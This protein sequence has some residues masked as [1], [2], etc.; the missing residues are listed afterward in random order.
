MHRSLIPILAALIAAAP[1]AHAGEVACWF[2]NGVVVVPAQLAGVAGD[3]ILD[4]ATPLTQM[5]DT[6]AQGAGF[7][8]TALTG[9][10][11]IAG[12]V[13]P[14]QPAAVA[15]LDLRTGALPTPIAGVIGA[16]ALKA[17]VLDVQFA[18]CRVALW[19][20]G[21]TP[22]FGR[23]DSLPLD[24]S[25]AVPTVRASVSDGARTLRG[26]FALAVGGDTAVRLADDLAAVPGAPKPKEL[27]RGGAAF[28]RLRALSFAGGLVESLPAGLS[29]AAP[30]RPA[31][32]IGAPVLSR[33]RLRLDMPGGRLWFAPSAPRS[34]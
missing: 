21:Q 19:R 17:Y 3:Y 6:Q 1:A 16:D 25:G 33:Y 28:P 26:P 23:A 12:L 10:L 24:M 4:P 14:A 20:P 34:K 32:E 11:R 7:A 18:P 29:P 2:E 13:I 31:G 8:A 15:N 30:E 5:G 27:Y 22:P 9:E